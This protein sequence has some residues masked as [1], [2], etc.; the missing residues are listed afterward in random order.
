MNL[1][2]KIG[3]GLMISAVHTLTSQR[4]VCRKK[5]HLCKLALSLRSESKTTTKIRLDYLFR[6][7]CLL[8]KPLADRTHRIMETIFDSF[9]AITG[10]RPKTSKIENIHSCYPLDRID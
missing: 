4:V 3:T 5:K 7:L 8:D 2:W 9:V 10:T 6:L 1:Y